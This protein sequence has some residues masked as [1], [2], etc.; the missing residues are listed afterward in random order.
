MLCP[1]VP[2][3][4]RSLHLLENMPQPHR[5]C[6]LLLCPLLASKHEVTPLRLT[7]RP[8]RCHDLLTANTR[9]FADIILEDDDL[10]SSFCPLH[11]LPKGTLAELRHGS[12]H[13]L[14]FFT[15]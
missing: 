5:F 3:M 9:N 7:E 8:P 11:Y 12:F 13:S 6:L 2:L 1:V 15:A 10:P 4:Q 14:F